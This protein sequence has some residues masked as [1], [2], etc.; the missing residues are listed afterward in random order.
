MKLVRVARPATQGLDE[1]IWDAIAC[2]HR[3]STY[4]EAVAGKVPGNPSHCQNLSDP[5]GEDG[6]QQ[7]PAILKHP[8]ELPLRATYIK[9]A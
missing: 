3:G 2:S 1:V 8:A 4:T 7:R 9:H 6:A 5:A